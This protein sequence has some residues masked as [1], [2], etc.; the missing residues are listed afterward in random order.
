MSDIE[1]FR[2]QTAASDQIAQ[3]YATLASDDR[4]PMVHRFWDVPFYQALSALTGSGKT[5]ILA[6]AVAQ[7]RAH[8][9]DEPIVLWI[10]KSKAVIDQTFANFEPGGKYEHLLQGLLVGYLVDLSPDM[11]ADGSSANIALATVG[12]FNQKDRADG[13]LR[14]HKTDE[15]SAD[16]PLWTLLKERKTSDGTRRPLIVV[17]DE[18]HN[19]SDQQT[20]LLLELEP[21]AFL[22]ASAT[23]KTPARVARLIDR[24]REHGWSDAQLITAISSKAVVEM[25]LVKKQIIM[26]GY[27]SLMEEA[28][29]NM[30]EAMH[31]ATEKAAALQAGFVPKAIY[32]CRTN[33]S[34]EDGLADNAS[35]PFEE[36]KA[37][38]I[39]IWRY[40]V[41][42]KGVDP[43][44]IAV[45]CDLRLDRKH[46]PPPEDFVLFSGGDDD[47]SVFTAGNYRH[48][49]FNLSLQE[50]WD[51]P[52]CGF[53]YIDKSMGS[54]VQVEQIIGRALRQP[55][56]RHYGDPDLNTAHFYI[57][58]DNKQIFPQILETVRKKIAAEI[59]EVK[60]EGFADSRERHRTRYEPK[61]RLTVPEIH[62]NSSDALAPLEAALVLINDYREDGANTTGKGEMVRAVQVIGDGSK[63]VISTK[64]TAHANRVLARWI[65][66]RGIQSLYPEVVKTID[67]S[68]PKFD[69]RIEITSVAA[70]SLRD[71]AEKLVDAYLENSDLAFEEENP[72]TVGPVLINPA[73]L[74]TFENALHEGYSDMNGKEIE[75][76]RALESA[77][78]LWA[79]NPSNGGFSIPLLEKGD[80]RNFYP[81]FLVWK[82]GFVFALDPKGDHLIG[83]DAGLKLLDIRDEKGARRI[84]VRL[85]TQ[86]RW[87]DPKTKTSPE[88]LTV[89]SMSKAG[90]P[91]PKHCSTI[92]DA[93]VASL[94]P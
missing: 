85:I 14:I 94:K 87:S 56:A 3:R 39:L 42:H 92:E 11:I 45:Y 57:R 9:S 52:A 40:L 47:F 27:A 29:D 18:G 4:R 74:E 24:L 12:T 31:R 38:P 20:D 62:I 81:D 83:K 84:I 66:R 8:M 32:V 65:L 30:L 54:S 19:L 79:R 36:R 90:K 50:G 82:D 93:V 22:V 71:A 10:S 88:G 59:P 41:E 35:R 34:Q 44:D 51:D 13:T 49:I 17:Y 73:K 37:P 43:K 76:A 86:G 80:S 26:Q 75:F 7:I 53:A 61:E 89:W 2:F 70:A 21:S 55:G 48:I 63:A 72:Y 33:I 68:N 58:V 1:L 16:E 60:L 46:N 23:M 77:G 6:D 28:L 67:W 69:A 25:G 78:V 91:K 5:P 15:D 64:E